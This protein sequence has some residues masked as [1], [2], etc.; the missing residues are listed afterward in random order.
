MLVN[1]AGIAGV[2]KPTQEITEAEWVR[3]PA[4]NVKGVF[5][6]VKHIAVRPLVWALFAAVALPVHASNWLVL[7]ATEPPGAPKLGLYAAV[8]IEYQASGDTPLLAGAWSGQPDQFNRF[9]PRYSSGEILRIPTAV[10]GVHG[11]LEA[12]QLNYR[13]AAITGENAIVRGLDGA[14]GSGIRVLDASLTLNLIPHAHLRAGLFRQPLGDEAIDPQ[15]RHVNLSHVTQQM[16]QERYFASNGSVNGSANLDLG[17]VSAFRDA[18][19]EVFDAIAAGDWE[20]TYAV[21]LGRG[22]GVD[23]TLNHAGIEKYVYWSSERIFGGKGA[24]R[25]GLKLYAWGQFGKRHLDVGPTQVKQTFARRRAGIGASL[26][27]GPGSVAAE[28]IHAHGMIYHGPDGGTVPGRLSN[29]GALVAGYNVLPESGSHGWYVDGGYRVTQTLEL[30]LRYDVLNRGTDNPNNEI[31][32]QGITVGGSYALAAKT[33][34]I[35][36]YQLRRYDAPRLSGA[37]E[38]N[39]L[40]DGVDNRM[41]IRLTQQFSF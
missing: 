37:S 26:G 35:F 24:Q 23:P 18:G 33:Q 41:G 14:Y 9:G 2:D 16:V 6:G 36:D 10:V 3:V 15:Q 39:V 40:L 32:F 4:I 30:R 27:K 7:D 29:N 5:F 1:N 25:D 34:L 38:T 17:P 13:L 21:M 19:V 31:R 20:H 8:S 28:W 11:R 22:S 12:G